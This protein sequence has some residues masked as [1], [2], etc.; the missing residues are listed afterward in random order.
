MDNTNY[1]LYQKLKRLDESEEYPFHMP[2][3]KRMDRA[4]IPGGMAHL[5]I[6]EIEGFDNL[7]HAEGILKEAMENAAKLYH[8]EETYFLVN[9][10]T[11]GI[12]TAISTAVR[13]KETLIL[14]RNAHASAYHGVYL[15]GSRIYSLFPDLL[16]EYGLY[17]VVRPEEVKRAL[18]A[19]PEAK[20]VM[21]TSPTYDGFVSDVEKIAQI[22]HAYDKILIVDEAHGAHFGLDERLPKS[23]IS[24]G[25]DLVIH[26]LHK[27]LPALTQTALLHVNGTRVDRER[28]R[29]FLK[30]YQTSSPSYLL[31]GSADHCIRQIQNHAEEWFERFFE[32]RSAF[33]EQIQELRYLRI[34]DEK[35][36]TE[37]GMK[38]MDPGKLLILTQ[39]S[40][41]TGKE[42][43]DILLQAYHLQMEMADEYHVVAIM[44][45]MDE[46]SGL[47]RL[48]KALCE[49]DVSCPAAR[50][51]RLEPER[52]S[53]EGQMT[54]KASDLVR[55]SMQLLT[56]V[57]AGQKEAPPVHTM[58]EVL[59][60]EEAELEVVAFEN[61]PGH[62]AAETIYLYPPGIPLILS[63]ER[64]TRAAVELIQQYRREHLPVQGMSDRTGRTVRCLK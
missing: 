64:I 60:A 3:H 54:G 19:A 2:G 22:V 30:I 58:K 53:Q 27:T 50:Q 11:C 62:I 10:S 56:Q 26:S 4:G 55:A 33:M 40:G 51:S 21:I 32:Y 5:D 24:C 36:C 28:L 25:A 59:E 37:N 39:E 1:S 38:A 6:T 9:G 41:Y 12:L 16:E 48:A 29:R 8:S 61:S 42:V 35:F 20:A 13:E 46:W 18:E 45:V 49:I 23:S 47:L 7:H 43:Q 57:I 31:M 17:G 34:A 63:G 44:T 14:S 52:Q 15:S